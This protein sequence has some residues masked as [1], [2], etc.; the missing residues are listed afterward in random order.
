M[1]RNPTPPGGRGHALAGRMR[2]GHVSYQEA[3]EGEA[4]PEQLGPPRSVSRGYRSYT[5]TLPVKHTCGWRAGLRAT[6]ASVLRP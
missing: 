6:A 2:V 4:L 3:Q 5:A 1:N